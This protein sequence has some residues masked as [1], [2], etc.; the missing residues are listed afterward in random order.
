MAE[1]D[2]GIMSL[3]QE[4]CRVCFSKTAPRHITKGIDRLCHW[5]I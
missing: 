4:L 2:L 3:N 1:K 5:L